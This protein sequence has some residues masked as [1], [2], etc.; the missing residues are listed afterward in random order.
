MGTKSLATS[1][2]SNFTES[3]KSSWKIPLFK[4]ENYPFS[5]P[6][7]LKKLFKRSQPKMSLMCQNH[8]PKENIFVDFPWSIFNMNLSSLRCEHWIGK[9][10]YSRIKKKCFRLCQS[11]YTKIFFLFCKIILT[12]NS[13][14]WHTIQWLLDRKDFFYWFD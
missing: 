9:F 13:S 4:N 3:F 7:P 14:F 6:P 5:T 11:S 1:H 8:P 12:L 10:I 2:K